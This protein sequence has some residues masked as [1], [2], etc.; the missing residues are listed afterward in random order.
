MNDELP[1][2]LTEGAILRYGEYAWE[3]SAFPAALQRAPALGYAC[4]GGQIWFL[5]PDDAVY[6]PFWLEANAKDRTTDEA[7]PEYSRRSCEEVLAR[8]NALVN[9]TDFDQECRKFRSLQPLVRVL[10]N[11]YFVIESEFSALKLKNAGL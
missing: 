7:W 9:G 1:H 2:E 6:E 11:A 8:F 4:L 3:L 10:I 5:F